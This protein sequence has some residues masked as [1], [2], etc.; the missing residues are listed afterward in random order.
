MPPLPITTTI[1]ITKVL[2]SATTLRLLLLIYGT[3]QD[4]HSALKYTDIDYAVFTD[5]ARYVAR[6]ESPYARATYR[7]T[8]LLA[9]LLYP[10]SWAEGAS[11]SGLGVGLGT[12]TLWFSFGKILFSLSDILAG[13]LVYRL[14]VEGSGGHG[15]GRQMN[16]P[17]ALCYVSGAWLL[18]P[19][20]AN[21]STRGSSE[22][23]LGVLVSGL[24]W[25]VLSG[26]VGLAGFLLGL[27]VHF[28]IYPFVYGVSVFWWL[29]GS[30]VEKDEKDEKDEKGEGED[31]KAIN[32]QK[33]KPILSLCLMM[34]EVKRLLTP[35]RLRFTITALSTFFALNVAMYAIYDTPFLQHTY[36]HHLSRVDHRHNFSPYSTLL[37]LSAARGGGAG[38]DGGAGGAGGPRGGAT[39][40]PFE[41]LAFIPQLL[42]SVFA[43]PLVLARKDLPGAMLAQTF[44]FVAFNKVCTSQV[45]ILLPLCGGV[46]VGARWWC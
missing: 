28:K 24:L 46:A 26:W 9:W 37:Y 36:L 8:P 14:L 34:L 38:G 20:V 22:G 1:T 25:A 2:I 5:A 30:Q 21:I 18:N 15:H 7:Y 27:G 10:T 39:G 11:A 42:L 40:I 33:P 41:S 3:W 16:P 17:K 19:M 12:E 4:T 43:I 29:D 32:A 23:L 44:A 35:N 6:G 13:W 45:C 31:K